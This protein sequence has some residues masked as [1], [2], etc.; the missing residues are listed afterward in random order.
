MRTFYSTR[1]NAPGGLLDRDPPSVFIVEDDDDLRESLK[2]II[3]SGGYRH[4]ACDSGR[5]ALEV[6][7]PERAG[8]VLI[9]LHLPDM[10]GLQLRRELVAKDCRQPFIV[11]TGTRDVGLAI[12][13]L[14]EGAVDYVQK[15]F[16]PGELLDRIAKA[17]DQD[18]QYRGLRNRLKG[19]TDREREVLRPVTAG[20]ATK[21]IARDLG[22]STRTVDVHRHNI[23][24]KMDVE[25][26]VQLV[27]VLNQHGQIPG[28][29]IPE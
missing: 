20:R 15:P 7:A 17:M 26:V 14:K 11:V 1:T 22:I 19:L 6:I 5:Q 4:V 2:R 25:S 18:R 10:D 9:D 16:K 21:A 27:H 28:G 12:R 8:C 29:Q 13:S 24:K 23:L 3:G